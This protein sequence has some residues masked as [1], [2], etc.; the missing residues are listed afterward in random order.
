M[1]VCFCFLQIRGISPT[2]AISEIVKGITVFAS[3][4]MGMWSFV[5]LVDSNKCN[6]ESV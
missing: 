4:E 6:F 3:N 2:D 1:P 5:W